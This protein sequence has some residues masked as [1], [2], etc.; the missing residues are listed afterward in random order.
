MLGG[1]GVYLEEF[2]CLEPGAA[3]GQQ[4]RRLWKCTFLA[5][6]CCVATSGSGGPAQAT[7]LC[8]PPPPLK[9][10]LRG[11]GAGISQ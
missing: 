2:L 7:A 3:C 9:P 5:Y 11:Q 8:P 4:R 6:L 1:P 10:R